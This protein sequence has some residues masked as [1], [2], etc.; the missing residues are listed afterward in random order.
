MNRSHVSCCHILLA[1]LYSGTGKQAHRPTLPADTQAPTSTCSS[2]IRRCTLH[3]HISPR[4]LALAAA[5]ATPPAH[6]S[7]RY[8][9]SHKHLFL[10]DSPLHSPRAHLATCTRPRRCT[11]H[12]TRT[13]L[14]RSLALRLLHALTRPRRACHRA[15][16]RARWL[17]PILELIFMGSCAHLQ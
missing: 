7:C 16:R 14:V 9:G 2:K 13:A 17:L 1:S 6:P 4:A 15:R 8:A 12:T 3:V 5:L 11:G 10:Q